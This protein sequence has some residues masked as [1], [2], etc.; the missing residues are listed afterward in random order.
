MK[1]ILTGVMVGALAAT[2]LGTIAQ[3]KPSL[4]LPAPKAASV[5]ASLQDAAVHATEVSAVASASSAAAPPVTALILPPPA[6]AQV[7]PAATPAHAAEVAVAVA[8]PSAKQVPAPKRHVARVSPKSKPAPADPYADLPVNAPAREAVRRSTSWAENDNASVSTGKDGR[9]VFLFGESMPTV[10]CAPLRVCDIELQKGEKV[11]GAPQVGD[12][13]FSIEPGIVGAGN[14]RVV[15][16]L[17]K[18]RDV[19]LDTNLMIPTDRRMYR[20]RLVSDDKNY[21]SVISWDYPQDDAIAWDA[22]IAAQDAHAAPV[23]ATMPALTADTLD[24]NFR[25]DVKKGRPAWTPVRVFSDGAH[26]YVQLPASV[27]VNEAPAFFAVGPDGKEELVNFRLKGSYFVIDRLVKKAILV[28]GVGGHAERVSI[29]YGCKR[30]LFQPR[31]G[32]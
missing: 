3:E 15:H 21:V 26:T 18:P 11:I 5:P 23:V 22:A 13:R 12:P 24:F 2:A 20:V 17:V 29:E 28:S 14:D 1:K 10:V 27:A 8:S 32:G 16:V 30:G 9:V 25:I 6:H 7:A 19:G 4:T 31:C